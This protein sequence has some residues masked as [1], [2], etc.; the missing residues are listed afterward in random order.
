MRCPFFVLVPL[1]AVLQTASASAQAKE[2]MADVR[3]L[4]D[5][6]LEGR[7][8]GTEGYRKAAAYVARQFEQAGLEPAGTDGWYQPIRFV[9]RRVVE[10]R[11]SL[12]LV[13][14]GVAERLA[15]G[16]DAVLNLRI[17]PAP[18]IEAPLVFVGYGVSLPEAGM[19][20]LDGIDLK[21]KVAVVLGGAP[22]GVP[23]A[24]LAHARSRAVF[25]DALRRAGAIGVLSILNPRTMEVAWERTARGR[26]N[27]QLSFVESELNETVGQQFSA[28]LNPAAAPRLFAGT[29]HTFDQLVALTARGSRLPR[30]TLPVSIKATVAVETREI[31]SRNVA[32]VLRGTD[33]KLRDEYVVIT[34]HLDHVGVGK[35]EYGD[36]IY[37]GAMDNASGVATLLETARAFRRERI[38]PARSLV[39]L[40]VTAEEKGLMGSRH[41][42]VHP[43]VPADKIVA[44][45]NTDLFLPINPLERLVVFGLD[46]SDLADDVRRAAGRKV[47]VERDPRPATNAFIR[48]DQYSFVRQG[49]PAVAF[50]VGA[51]P[52]SP[53]EKRMV[54]WFHERYHGASDDANQAIDLQ[55][56]E[57]FNRF[58]VRLVQAVADRRTRP[59]WRKDSFFRR[60]AKA[61]T[62]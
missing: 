28:Q 53:A 9:S 62:S 32:G 3:I 45:L 46:E 55:S 36:S 13:R 41:Y 12:A 52:G 38:R 30:F 40:A 2:W 33:P 18:S 43:T 44:N 35:P 14:N 20:E 11:S 8:P 54:V 21:G 29:E 23:A 51:A 25:W 27:P 59:T 26:F 58:Y 50:A 4:A 6:S 5:D 1:A 10:E 24:L 17:D 56:A 15:L 39:F 42:A 7:D 57:D 16:N 31:E 48:S 19:D 60:F 47:S 61:G 34:A 37:N 22:S 49:I